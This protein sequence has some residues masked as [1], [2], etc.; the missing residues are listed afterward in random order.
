MGRI[1][2]AQSLMCSL[3]SSVLIHTQQHLD[4][5]LKNTT[6]RV[7]AL[8]PVCAGKFVPRPVTDND[9]QIQT[10]RDPWFREVFSQTN[11]SIF[12]DEPLRGVRQHG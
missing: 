5:L 3:A 7:D 11:N 10:I 9:P 8:L 1:L 12:A 6:L 2:L 4:A